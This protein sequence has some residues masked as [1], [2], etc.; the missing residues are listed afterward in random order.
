MWL[1]VGKKYNL[2]KKWIKDKCRCE[3]KNPINYSVCQ[4]YYI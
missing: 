1:F 2:N 4:K 3:S